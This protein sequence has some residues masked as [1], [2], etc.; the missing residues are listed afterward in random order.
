MIVPS[1]SL[2]YGLCGAALIG[3]GLY[4]FVAH[5]RLIRRV[6]AFNVIGS[7]IFLL[8]GASAY[9]DPAAGAD[10]VPQAMII[11]GIVV[12]LAA[13]ALALALIVAHARLAQSG[14]LPE[15][16]TDEDGS[17]DAP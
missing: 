2:L 15:D 16:E 7:G 5:R 9:R 6:L 12:A 3:L 17:E 8:F 1:A 14:A 10:P 4:G 11:T 13:T